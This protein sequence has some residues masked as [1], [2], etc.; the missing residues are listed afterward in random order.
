MLGLQQKATAWILPYRP[1][2]S[3]WSPGQGKHFSP[4]PDIGLKTGDDLFAHRTLYKVQ[5]HTLTIPSAVSG[6]IH[7]LLKL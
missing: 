3:F 6:I 4:P 1:S 2:V 5:L 7:D